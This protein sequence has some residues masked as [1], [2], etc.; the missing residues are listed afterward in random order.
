[1]K[2][3]FCLFAF[4]AA[5]FL[6]ASCG[7]GSGNSRIAGTWETDTG[8]KT[9]TFRGNSVI[10]E[11]RHGEDRGTFAVQDD[12]IELSW[13]VLSGEPDDVVEVATFTLTGNTLEVRGTAWANGVYRKQ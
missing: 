6:L 9:I 12:R 8:S 4:L 5:V 13:N 11:D 10:L 2:R 1:M 7:S 3:L